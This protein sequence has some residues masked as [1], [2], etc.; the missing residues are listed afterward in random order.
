M[1]MVADEVFCWLLTMLGPAEASRC[2][3]LLSQTHDV[4]L[5]SFEQRNALSFQN[6]HSDER[7]DNSNKTLL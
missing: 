6:E 7:L 1:Q 3:E 4:F 5:Q 2:Y